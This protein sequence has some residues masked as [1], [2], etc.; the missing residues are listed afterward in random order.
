MSF[1]PATSLNEIL[2]YLYQ[3]PNTVIIDLTDN[4]NVT[5]TLLFELMGPLNQLKLTGLILTNCY[6]LTHAGLVHF[7]SDSPSLSAASSP[8][9]S[10]AFSLQI[11]DLSGC[12]AIVTDDIL[13]LI[14]NNTSFC[15]RS[16]AVRNCFR[17]TDLGLQF[18]IRDACIHLTYLDLGGCGQITDKG[19]MNLVD[20][21]PNLCHLSLQGCLKVTSESIAALAQNCRNLKS[22]NLQ[23]CVRIDDGALDHLSCHCVDLEALNFQG[24]SRLTDISLLQVVRNCPNLSCLDIRRCSGITHFA[25]AT[26]L[27]L[28]R[29]IHLHH[30][31]NPPTYASESG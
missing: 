1:D 8:S 2:Q 7:C 31:Q 26:L 11:L 14:G 22:L 13:H 4:Q 30:D 28:P 27:S 5:D 17:L 19:V 29:L 18:L 21:L 24:C 15:L 6:R 3:N 20:H 9:S 25:T 23:G 10:N 16:L 12:S